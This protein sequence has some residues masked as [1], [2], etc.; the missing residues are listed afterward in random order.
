M[1]IYE[2]RPEEAHT[3]A[4]L[5]KGF[6]SETVHVKV[7][8]AYT[9][10]KYEQMV[11]DGIACLFI[12][13][14]GGGKMIGGLGCIKG[15]DLHSPRTIAVETYWYVHP[16]HRGEGKALLDHFENWAKENGCDATAMIHL[17][18]SMPES[19]ESLYVRRGYSLVEKHFIKKVTR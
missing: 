7:D 15:Q 6:E 13:E 8:V 2:A 16:E 18:D 12:M 9:G 1:I 17:S 5:M 4:A 11:R 3:I 14:D 19:L 10:A